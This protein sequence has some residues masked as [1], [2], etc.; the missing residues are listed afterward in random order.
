MAQSINKYFKLYTIHDQ[1]PSWMAQTV[2]LSL[3]ISSLNF[4]E[5]NFRIWLVIPVS[6]LVQSAVQD[7]LH[8]AR[9]RSQTIQN[10]HK[11][12]KENDYNKKETRFFFYT[13]NS[14]L[15][16]QTLLEGRIRHA[17]MWILWTRFI[18]QVAIFRN[19]C[20]PLDWYQYLR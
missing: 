15:I 3:W 12:F 6:G 4:R 16:W 17:A 13:E 19:C 1:W 7:E 14:T 5:F 18:L 8:Q 20:S 2:S 10:L 9:K 11:L